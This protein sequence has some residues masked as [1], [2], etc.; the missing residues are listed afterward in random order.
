MDNDL[1]GGN[2]IILSACLAGKN[3]C[4]DGK[5]N[6]KEEFRGLMD[7]GY[8]LPVCA[9]E[10]GGLST[11]R[12]PAEITGGSGEDVLDGKAR[13][14]NRE[15][16]DVTKEYLKGAYEVL[17]LVRK[18]G[19]KK[20]IFKVRSSSCGRDKIY[21]GSFNHILKRGNGVTCA[22]LLREGVEVITDEE[23]VAQRPRQQNAA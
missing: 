15:G 19:I 2:L 5:N 23:Y 11:P 10:L 17:N 18:K 20:A 7:E 16:K 3:C 14:V 1:R 22:L 21:D 8:A 12:P 4:W 9:E 13:V 6:K